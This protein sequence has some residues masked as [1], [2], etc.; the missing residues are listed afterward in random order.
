[1]SGNL[2]AVRSEEA[3]IA[4]TLQQAGLSGAGGG[5]FPSYVKWQSLSETD[6]LLVNHQESEPNCYVDKWIGR[7]YADELAI[8]FD[9]LLEESLETI[10]VGAK[11]KDRDPWVRPLE[12]ATGAAV[13]TPDDLPV[14]ADAESGVVITYTDEKYELGMENV[15]LQQATGTI[16]G[17]DLPVD[18]G[19]IVQNT[20]TIYNAWRAFAEDDPVLHKFVHVDGYLSDGSRVPH[21]M[22]KAPIGT[23]AEALLEAAGVDPD[24]LAADRRLVEGGPGWC[25]KVQRPADRYGVTKHTNCFMLLDEDDV[26][27]HRYGNERIDVIE[28]LDWDHDDP[29]T[30]P[31][32]VDPDRVHIPIVTNEAYADLVTGSTPLV[33]FGDGVSEGQ[34]VAEPNTNGMFSVAHHSPISGE[35]A[36]VT[37]R[38]VEVRTY[39]V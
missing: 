5:G 30:E 32:P 23:S 15:L 8:L 1:M 38:E 24:G 26:E 39:S 34:L 25:F 16:L 3:E 17:K 11:L 28:P 22:F 29:D 20:E 21:R 33:E 9:A 31:T 13:R 12:E 37:P 4:T 27:K 18:Y 35:V 10:I 6:K 36:D 19:W 2:D 14:D 7:E